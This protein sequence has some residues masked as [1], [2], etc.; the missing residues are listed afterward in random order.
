METLLL[1]MMVLLIPLFLGF[2]VYITLST[3]KAIFDDWIKIPFYGLMLIII[4]CQNLIYLDISIRYSSGLVIISALTLWVYVIVFKG[5]MALSALRHI[6]NP[7]SG[8][9]AYILIYTFVCIPILALG[10]KYFYGKAW[11]DQI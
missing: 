5:N 4:L 1:W 11:Y 10:V 3:N 6:I 8:I 9:Y 2:P 7:S